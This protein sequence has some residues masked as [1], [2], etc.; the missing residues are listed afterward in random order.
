MELS[1]GVGVSVVFILL[2]FFFL[3]SPSVDEFLSQ[4][5]VSQ[6][7]VTTSHWQCLL[8]HISL[9]FDLKETNQRRFLFNKNYFC[10]KF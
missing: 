2:G 6:Q 3:T 1:V 5:R 4:V 9:S 8:L 7:Q 10:E